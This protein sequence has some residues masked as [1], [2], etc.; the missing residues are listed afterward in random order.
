MNST[1]RL[2]IP[3]PRHG[4]WLWLMT[5]ILFA[6][7]A[8]CAT[9]AYSLSEAS[10]ADVLQAE[11]LRRQSKA[12]PQPNLGKNQVEEQKRWASLQLEKSFDWYPVFAALERSSESDIELLEFHPDKAGRRLVLRGEARSLEA[13]AD[14]M[15]RL[16]EQRAL[17]AV[18]LAHE[19][20]M[21]RGRLTT[22]SFEIGATIN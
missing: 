13:L 5:G 6:V 14:Y 4:V 10:A 2:M 15:Q 22:V 16:S 19:K 18:Y 20:G 1:R 9:D 21:V 3:R 17:S 8:S 7:A 12:K 11:R